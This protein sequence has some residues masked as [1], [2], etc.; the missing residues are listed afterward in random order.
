VF[1][2]ALSDE[3]GAVSLDDLTSTQRE[4]PGQQAVG[5][6]HAGDL[7]ED[8]LRAAHHP[9][10]GDVISGTMPRAHQAALS[11]D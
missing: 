11:V 6:V 10:G 1:A 5:S 8:A 3:Y 9:P 4:G 2:F 7:G